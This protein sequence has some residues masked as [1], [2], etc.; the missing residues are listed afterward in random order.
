ML[1]PLAIAFFVFFTAAMLALPLFAHHLPTEV[2]LALV[3]F[4]VGC[5]FGVVS[6]SDPFHRLF[7]QAA[8]MLSLAMFAQ[9]GVKTFRARSQ[10]RKVS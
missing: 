9:F 6:L 2:W 10:S 4:G 3:V 1:I 7:A 8:L 5:V